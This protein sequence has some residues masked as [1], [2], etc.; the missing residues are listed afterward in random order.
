MNDK[1]SKFDEQRNKNEINE[2]KME[3]ENKQL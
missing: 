3:F 1:I 2:S